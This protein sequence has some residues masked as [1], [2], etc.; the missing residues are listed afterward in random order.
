MD[1]L[2][3]VMM[4]RGFGWNIIRSLFAWLDTAVYTVFGWVMQ[5]IFDICEIS[6]NPALQNFYD[7]IHTRIYGVLAIFML[8]KITVSMLTY[9]VNPD[10]I[11]DKERGV[12]KMISR[13][14]LSLVML[15]GFPTLFEFFLVEVQPHF[16]EALPRIVLGVNG[17]D[18]ESTGSDMQLAGDKISFSIYNGVWFNQNCADE[19]Q[20]DDQGRING[21]FMYTP[22]VGKTFMSLVPEHINDE[23]EDDST[24]KYD[25]YPV[26]GLV[27]GIV[28]T[29]IITGICIDVA[30]RLFKLIILQMI[31]PIPIMSYIDPKSSKDGAFSKWIK[32]VI[33]VYLDLFIKLAVVYFIILVINSLIVNG[34]VQSITASLF[35]NNGVLRGGLTLVALVVGLLFF[36]K[37]A[38]KFISDA[39]GIKTG[40]NGKLFGGLGKVMAA[41]A[42]GAGTLGS[43]IAAGRA[44]YMSDEARDKSHNPLRF[45]KNIGA[46]LFGGLFGAKAGLGAALGA[47]DHQARAAM[48]AMAK[49][50]A[51]NLAAGAAGS[52]AFGRLLASGSSLLYGETGA[53]SGKRKIADLEA[54]K[55]ALDAVKSR[56]SSEMVKQ[57]WT[58]S[59]IMDSEGHFLMTNT[60]GDAIDGSINYKEFMARK[61]AAAAAGQTS[62]MISLFDDNG[63]EYQDEISMADA[64]RF[65]GLI[66]KG[67]ESNY[68]ER[69][70]SGG[71]KEDAY[72]VALAADAEAKTPGLKIT[73]RDSVTKTSDQKTIEITAA[74]RENARKEQ[75]ARFS[76]K[77]S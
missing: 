14:I 25:Y 66:L 27:V 10:T 15:L 29:L 45:A 11:G 77:N 39:L 5:L 50:N 3:Y 61:N 28:I 4:E 70:I 16:L 37:D 7:D 74:K 62:F 21:C 35:K 54:S 56:A 69:T 34:V 2:I 23:G 33:S 44:S 38:P 36:A 26:V 8:F 41:G 52:T 40:E 57:E 17:V 31:A 13:V 55:A 24:Y 58:R 42:I 53:A 72:M 71:D 1:N 19:N 59:K 6:S 73:N 32:M 49:K 65:Q 20:P 68:I 64:E 48:D 75:N 63:N 18:N 67:N 76:G 43:A 22:E 9:L 51:T 12:S 47:K 46:G 60:Q 30:I